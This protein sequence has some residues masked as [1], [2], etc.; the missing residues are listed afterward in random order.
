MFITINPFLVTHASIEFC[1]SQHN[2]CAE[3]YDG[4]DKEE[5]VRIRECDDDDEKQQWMFCRC[6]IGPRHNQKLYVTAGETRGKI[7]KGKIELHA[8]GPEKKTQYFRT[9][10]SKAVSRKF[11]FKRSK[12]GKYELCLTQD[13]HPRDEECLRFKDCKKDEDNAKGAHDETSH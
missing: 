3:C 9:F 4:C 10:D 13:H 7:D 5:N 11:Q 12:R 1:A 6:T 2:R 8:C